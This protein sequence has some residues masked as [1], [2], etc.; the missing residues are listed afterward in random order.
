L[1]CLDALLTKARSIKNLG[2]FPEVRVREEGL[3]LYLSP[4]L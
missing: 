2:A 1:E 4:S 3:H